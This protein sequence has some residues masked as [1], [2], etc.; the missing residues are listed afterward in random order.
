ML[1]FLILKS[2]ARHLFLG[3]SILP[4]HTVLALV[5]WVPGIHEI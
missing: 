3:G 4:Q 2:K 1:I 5:P